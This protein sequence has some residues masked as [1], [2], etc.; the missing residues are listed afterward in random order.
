MVQFYKADEKKKLGAV[1]SLFVVYSF[2]NT[3]KINPNNPGVCF[4]LTMLL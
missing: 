4:F 2:L 1:A 3:L